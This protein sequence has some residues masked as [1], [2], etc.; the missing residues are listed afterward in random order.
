MSE[1]SE[2]AEED[3]LPLTRRQVANRS[4]KSR[5]TICVGQLGRPKRSSPTRLI[6]HRWRRSRTTPRVDGSPQNDP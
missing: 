6:K 2:V 5:I 4:G 3:D 1:I